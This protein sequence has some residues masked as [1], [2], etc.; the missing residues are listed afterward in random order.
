MP[1][2]PGDPRT[3]TGSV[4]RG[5]M[6]NHNLAL[7]TSRRELLQAFAAAGAGALLPGDRLTAQTKGRRID[8]HHQY[9]FSKTGIYPTN[10]NGWTPEKSLEQM[11]KFGIQT[12]I[13][14]T[15]GYGDE[16]YDGTPNGNALA[17]KSNDYAA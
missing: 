9:V 16:V 12:A 10:P 15:A 3:N 6:T 13:L 2:A 1:V 14:S 11:D 17:R 8:V 4:F 7:K 5:M